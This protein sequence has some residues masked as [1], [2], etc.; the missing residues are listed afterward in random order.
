MFCK[1]KSFLK[2]IN[3][4]FWRKKWMELYVRI[5][6][7][8]FQFQSIKFSILWNNWFYFWRASTNL[9]QNWPSWVCR[10]NPEDWINRKL[11]DQKCYQRTENAKNY[12]TKKNEYNWFEPC[13]YF[14]CSRLLP[15]TRSP[16]VGPA[17][18]GFLRAYSYS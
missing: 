6:S 2:F 15:G 3:Y 11:E 4:I 10:P 13:G 9:P 17:P 7:K 16:A 12:K 1:I 18:Y 5:F 14:L 8:M